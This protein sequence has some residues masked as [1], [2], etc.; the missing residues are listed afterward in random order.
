M[1]CLVINVLYKQICLFDNKHIGT[2]NM[3]FVN[4]HLIYSVL[5]VDK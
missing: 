1:V 5:I 2:F 3:F 4:K